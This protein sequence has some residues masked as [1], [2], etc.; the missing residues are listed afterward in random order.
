MTMDSIDD[1][2]RSDILSHLNSTCQSMHMSVPHAPTSPPLSPLVHNLNHCTTHDDPCYHCFPMAPYPQQHFLGQPPELL[3]HHN[4]MSPQAFGYQTM[5]S[6]HPK[7]PQMNFLERSLTKSHSDSS[8]MKMSHSQTRSFVN[9]SAS[10]CHS[11]PTSP[12]SSGPTPIAQE[13]PLTRP[14]PVWRPW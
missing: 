6:S 8:L 1:N 5:A 4:M 2:T 14:E 13:Q 10:Q 3:P 7:S 12:K 11:S 9:T